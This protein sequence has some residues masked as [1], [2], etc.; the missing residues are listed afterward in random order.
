MV[1]ST[2]LYSEEL[3]ILYEQ[4][5]NWDDNENLRSEI[6]KISSDALIAEPELA[7][8][9]PSI[10]EFIFKDI[11]NE[12]NKEPDDD[13]NT[14]KMQ[15]AL[16]LDNLENIL[17]QEFVDRVLELFDNI[18]STERIIKLR[19]LFFRR[20]LDISFD[21]PKKLSA[22]NFFYST[23]L[24]RKSHL[25][26]FSEFDCIN[27]AFRKNSADSPIMALCC[28]VIQNDLCDQRFTQS[29][30]RTPAIV[31]V[32]LLKE[33]VNCLWNLLEFIQ[34]METEH[35]MFIN[36]ID[37]VINDI[38]LAME[39]Q[40]H[41]IRSLKLYFVI[42]IPKDSHYLIKYFVKDNERHFHG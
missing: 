12:N 38:N 28:G 31:A 37:E 33:F 4:S 40:S 11:N 36:K 25:K 7:R 6:I 13:I 3:D 42:Y 30:F 17:S 22:R 20:C 23:N 10:M 9:C 27:I 5:E 26:P 32:T 19:C 1:R 29:K 15:L 24:K 14:N 34:N 16:D 2:G 35:L 41:L 8:M 21:L 18:P 39:C